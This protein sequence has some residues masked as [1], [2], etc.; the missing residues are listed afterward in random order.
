MKRIALNALAFVTALASLSCAAS[1]TVSTD[2]KPVLNH[3]GN[4]SFRITTKS[5]AAQRAFYRGLTWAYSFGH[6]AAEQEFRKALAADPDCAMAWW[7]IALV[8]GPH[9]NFPFVPPDKAAR[10]WEAVTNAQ[11][12]ASSCSLLEQSFIAALSKRYANPQPE[13]RAPLDQA[14]ADAMRA[15]WKANVKNPD[16][17]SLFA[18][19]AMDLHPWNYWSDG[20]PQPW[21]DE[22]VSA[23]DTALQLAPQHPGANHFYIHIIEASAT[24]GRALASADRLRKLV[25]D[26][27]HMVHMP[28]HIYA[29]VGRWEDAALANQKAMEVDTRYR[30]AFPRPGFYAMYMAHNAHFLAYV[31]MMQGRSAQSIALAN[32]VVSGIPQGRSCPSHPPPPR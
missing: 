1:P 19:A 26:S 5:A 12:L 17:A 3:L 31:S 22:I 10:A 13:D 25:P 29:R 28:S 2:S 21:T 7:G 9:I 16:A 30:A 32:D 18:E 8:N 24:P 23:L 20:K 11:R 4:Y 15:L 14:Y 6:F 27:S